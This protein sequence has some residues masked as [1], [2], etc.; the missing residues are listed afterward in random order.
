MST[1]MDILWGPFSVST[2]S[3]VTQCASVLRFAVV[4]LNTLC[5]LPRR[6]VVVR[7]KRFTG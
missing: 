2:P 1:G 6:N 7:L 3:L 5:Y 4:G